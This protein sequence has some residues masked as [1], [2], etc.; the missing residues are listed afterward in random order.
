MD[1]QVVQNNSQLLQLVISL[2]VPGTVFVIVLCL[3]RYV[4]KLKWLT[5]ICCAVIALTMLSIFNVS[6]IA[7]YA[8]DME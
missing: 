8:P 6:P 3:I 7:Q 5:A 4:A 2:A 1:V